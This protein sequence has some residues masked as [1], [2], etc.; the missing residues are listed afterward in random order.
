MCKNINCC[1]KN[2]DFIIIVFFL[3]VDNGK[4]IIRTIAVETMGYIL[5]VERY[6][7]IYISLLF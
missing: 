1:F 7:S 2:T 5:F 6:G 3:S 4:S